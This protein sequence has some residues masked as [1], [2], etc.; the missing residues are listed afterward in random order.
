M[1]NSI[2]RQDSL[3]LYLTIEVKEKEKLEK[4]LTFLANSGV[5]DLLKFKTEEELRKGGRPEY[6][7]A[8]LLAVTLLGFAF[9]K[10]SIRDLEEACKYDLRFIYLIRQETPSY[11]IFANF[12]NTFIV[13]KCNEI[14]SLLVKQMAKECDFSDIDAF[15]DG[16]KFEADAN[17][18]KFVY[19]PTTWHKKLCTK[20]RN[21]LKT[22]DIDRGLPEDE[23]FSSKVISEKV[24]ELS[25]IVESTN[26]EKTKKINK[27]KLNNLISYLTKAIEYE[28]KE[29]ICGSDRNSYYKSDNDATAMCLKTDYYSGLGSNMHAAY[30]CQI[31]VCQGLIY[32]F[33]ISQSRNDINDFI[34]L[35]EKFNKYYG[36]Y[37]KNVCADAGYGSYKNYQFLRDNKITSYV[38]HQSFSGNVSGK[39]PALYELL[40]DDTIK[41]LSGNIGIEVIIS[42][43]HPRQKGS[44]FYK[45][46]GCK[47]CLF[48][49]YCK[50][51]M[52]VKDEN[53][54]I[55]EINK[56]YER[57]KKQSFDNL[58]S[59]EGIEKRVNRSIQVEGAFGIIKQDMNYTRSRRAG[60]KKV[61]AEYM[62]TY[63]GYNIRKL[64]RFFDG[65]LKKE[66]WKA[67]K[68]IQEEVIKNPSAKRLANRVNK[69]KQANQNNE[70][71]TAYKKKY[72]HK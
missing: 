40:E 37:P 39:N 44:V 69:K 29:K 61:E 27:S 66:Y 65:K 30:N 21:L 55:F 47:Q 54:K 20:I 68:G 7:P 34:P 72:K 49:S 25:N 64:F 23:I 52:K 9:N 31:L 63:L 58:L 57:L 15:I 46:E 50:R 36:H 16:T 70:A 33:Y 53:F 10:S 42:N 43:R 22:I 12:I 3:F 45:V 32:S 28:E 59:V 24:T 56:E 13:P 8:D 35:L 60:I 14:F 1:E 4:F 5:Y 6:N 18:Y 71:K 41:C 11:K 62:L 51:F 38:K 67:P 19:K 48:S 26:D 17:K 2:T